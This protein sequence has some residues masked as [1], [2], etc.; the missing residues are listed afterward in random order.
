MKKIKNF[1]EYLKEQSG[2]GDAAGGIGFATLNGSGMGN[3]V[4]SQ[5]SQTPGDVGN[6]TIGSGDVA[7]RMGPYYKQT[8]KTY[9]KKK[10]KKKK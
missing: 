3:V 1:T 5:V 9:K 10:S 4:S 8:I 6:S 7:N 2:S